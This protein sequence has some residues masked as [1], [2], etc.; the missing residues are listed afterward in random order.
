MVI[1]GG[2]YSTAAVGAQ[3]YTD[4]SV[5]LGK[6]RSDESPHEAGAWEAV[7]QQN[8]RP[9][10]IA[11]HEDPCSLKPQQRTTRKN[12]WPAI[13]SPVLVEFCARTGAGE[14]ALQ[15]ET[16]RCGGQTTK[17]HTTLHCHLLIPCPKCFDLAAVHANRSARHPFRR[18]RYEKASRSAI[19]FRLA[20]AS[21]TRLVAET[22]SMASSTVMLWAG[23]HFSKKD[24]R[25]PVI[26]GPGDNAVDLYAVFDSLLGKCFR[27][28][29]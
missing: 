12:L 25:R 19:C 26:T 20:E 13:L 10:S 6:L 2:R 1:C 28:C 5:I 15:Q 8:G 11:A 23:A 24:R 9:L 3:V 21:D 7:Y 17:K 29:S 22:S 18:R 27:K 16:E 14:R 4:H